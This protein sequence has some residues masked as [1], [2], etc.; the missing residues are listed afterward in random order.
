MHRT[1][2]SIILAAVV[3]TAC[4]HRERQVVRLQ[5]GEAVNLQNFD[6]TSCP[7]S[8]AAAMPAAARPVSRNCLRFQF[9]R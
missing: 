1:F 8:G 2:H 5:P 3:L 6:T 4:A 7:L 9:A